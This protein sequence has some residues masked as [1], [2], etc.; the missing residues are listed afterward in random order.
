MAKIVESHIVMYEH[1]SSMS[2]SPAEPRLVHKLDDGS[3][4]LQIGAI[5]WKVISEDSFRRMSDIKIK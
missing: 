2:N 1:P 5:G 3:I 4:V